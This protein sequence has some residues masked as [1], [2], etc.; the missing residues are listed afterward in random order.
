[1][2]VIRAN[3]CGLIFMLRITRLSGEELTTIPCTDLSDVK[4]L[5]WRLC[6]HHGLPQ[7]F[8]QRV[9]HEGNILDDAVRLDSAMD[10]QVLTLA[11][12]VHEL[13]GAEAQRAKL[14]EA[15]RSGRFAE[16][17]YR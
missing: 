3:L 11:Q 8:C 4:A 2:H 9:F 12:P 13:L 7:R 16:A 10:L 1:M 15:A 14:Y 5:K 6:Q 17:G